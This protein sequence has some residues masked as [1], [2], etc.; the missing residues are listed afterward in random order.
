MRAFILPSHLCAGMKIIKC[1]DV[2]AARPR[3]G[4]PP[5]A[6]TGYAAKPCSFVKVATSLLIGAGF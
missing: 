6:V 5:R 3:L 1:D 2:G 4:N